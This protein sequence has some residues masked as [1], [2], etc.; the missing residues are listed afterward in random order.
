M[1]YYPEC[2]LTV[3]PPHLW[4]FLPPLREHWLNRD[5]RLYSTIFHYIPIYSTKKNE[6]LYNI[7]TTYS[8]KFNHFCTDAGNKKK[9]KT[10]RE[11]FEINMQCPYCWTLIFYSYS[12]SCTSSY[13]LLLYLLL[14]PTLVPPPTSYFC[15][16]S[17]FLLLCLLPLCDVI[18]NFDQDW[19]QC[20]DQ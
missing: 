17:Y 9:D 8:L 14:L 10:R 11:N 4:G 7:D 19:Y 5:R 3:C 16:S 20:R 18:R 1:F 15:T 12:Y 6:N 13:F 2:F